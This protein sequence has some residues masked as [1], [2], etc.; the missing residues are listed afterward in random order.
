MMDHDFHTQKLK[1]NLSETA[2]VN[3]AFIF[4]AAFI[5]SRDDHRRAAFL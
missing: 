2:R 3:F 4:F 5:F 1:T